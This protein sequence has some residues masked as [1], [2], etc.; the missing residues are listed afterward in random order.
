[1]SSIRLEAVTK[2]YGAVDAVSKLSLSISPGEFVT[3]LG[4]SGSGKTTT[5]RMVAGLE[6]PTEGVI[7]I[8]DRIVSDGRSFI[9]THK[10]KLGMV[11]QSY[12]VWPHKTVTENVAFP[13]KMRGLSRSDQ[14]QKTA[15]ML[16]RVGLGDYGER[17]PSQLSGGQQQRVSLAR[18]LVGE[19]EVILFDEPLSNLDAQLRDS[20][21]DLLSELH[22]SIGTTSIYVTH[23]QSEAM[24]LSDRVYIMSNGKLQQSGTPE[25]LYERPTSRFVADFIGAANTMAV[26][27]VDPA[28]NSVRL[29][30]QELL[31]A[32]V[33]RATASP[34]LV[35]RPHRIGFVTERNGQ[36]VLSATVRTANYL[37]DRMRYQLDLESGDG[38]TVETTATACRA[39]SGDKVSIHLPP[40]HCIVI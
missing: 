15:Q 14:L 24:V 38:V 16:K 21:R 2:S 40:E 9:P 1:M 18:A 19:P 7:S 23:D 17:Y 37:G 8:G 25:D 6:K 27:M 12:A 22:K 39:K 35:V 34:T 13:L 4:P 30:S 36:N 28:K 5:M 3:L 26:D 32:S 20:M 33:E 29:G 31:V 10:R 11:F